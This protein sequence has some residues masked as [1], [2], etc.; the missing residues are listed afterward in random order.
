MLVHAQVLRGSNPLVRDTLTCYE[1]EI[2]RNNTDLFPADAGRG[3]LPVMTWDDATLRLAAQ[4]GTTPTTGAQAPRTL[5]PGTAITGT[6]LT[7]R[8]PNA[9]VTLAANAIDN[10]TVG[11]RHCRAGGTYMQPAVGGSPTASVECALHPT[12]FPK[13]EGGWHKKDDRSECDHS[14]YNK[15]RLASVCPKYRHTNEVIEMPPWLSDACSLIMDA[16]GRRGLGSKRGER[17][18]AFTRRCM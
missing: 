7:V 5:Q 1:R 11:D 2:A 17:Q 6:L 12:L 13:G 18:D 4:Q 10:L 3:G 14:H 9:D 15:A 16:D 8:E